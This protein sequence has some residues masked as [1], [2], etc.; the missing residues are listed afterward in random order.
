[1][2]AIVALVLLLVAAP[3]AHAQD[4]VVAT[5][6]RPSEVREHDGAVLYSDYDAAID[7]YRLRVRAA[8]GTVRELRVAP[9]REPFDADLGTDSAGNLAA[10]VALPNGEPRGTGGG[11]DLFVFTVATGLARP[12]RNA[13]TGEDERAPAIDHGRI[14][15][16]R[17]YDGAKPIVYTKRLIAPRRKPSTRLPGVPTR[18]CTLLIERGDCTT[19]DRAVVTLELREGRLAQLVTYHVENGP[20]HRQNEI[21]LVDVARRSSRQVAFMTTGEGGQEYVGPSFAGSRLSWYRGCAVE[22]SRDFTALL[23]YRMGVGYDRADARRGL[24]GY[25]GTGDGTWQVRGTGEDGGCAPR[26]TLVWT[27]EPRWERIAADRVRGS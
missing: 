18:R 1:M 6:E 8:G 27:R 13:N 20:G 9:S 15:F 14:A 7:R 12:V 3:A 21:R 10:I 2:T 4:T 22:C 16:T 25:A 24:S 26:C 11:T 17:V 5:L 19:V 23:R